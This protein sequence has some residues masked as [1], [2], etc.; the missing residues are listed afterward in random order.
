MIY[1]GKPK[2]FH[3]VKLTRE[4][5]GE[6]RVLFNSK[7]IVFPCELISRCLR[8]FEVIKINPHGVVEI[9]RY[10]SNKILKV[11]GHSLKHFYDKDKFAY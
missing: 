4:K 9:R 10:S 3:D 6:K 7:L 8:P 2:A 1:K 11:N 5:A